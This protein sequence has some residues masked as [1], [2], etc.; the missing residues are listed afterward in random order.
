[1]ANNREATWIVVI[2][3]LVVL[4]FVKYVADLL[5]LPFWTAT[6]CLASSVG[7]LLLAGASMTWFDDFAFAR[8]TNVAPLLVALLWAA[9]WPAL[10]AWD[11][12]WSA[13]SPLDYTNAPFVVRGGAWWASEWTK[14]IPCFA[15][16][17][18]TLQRVGR[19][20]Y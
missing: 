4:G 6:Q 5:N 13:A 19:D 7:V 12:V 1:M 10:D 16:A 11:T 14:W 8:F 2:V 18:W 9:W 17:G 3:G 20:V 15:L